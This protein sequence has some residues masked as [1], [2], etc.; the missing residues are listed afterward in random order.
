[1]A[2]LTCRKWAV[3]QEELGV[4]AKYFRCNHH[5]VLEVHFQDSRIRLV[6]LLYQLFRVVLI[7]SSNNCYVANMCTRYL[8]VCDSV[9]RS[10]LG[11]CMHV[12][13]W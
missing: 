2:R 13:L 7:L 3:F 6:P 8:G 10:S 4:F 1:M 12:I 11:L 9:C 5:L